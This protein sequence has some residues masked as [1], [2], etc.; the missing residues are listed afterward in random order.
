MPTPNSTEQAPNSRRFLAF[1]GSRLPSVKP[2]SQ[3]PKDGAA[4][5]GVRLMM[6]MERWGS[7]SQ[8]FP[9][10]QCAS[11]PKRCGDKG[12]W[13]R[14]AAQ[15][16]LTYR[17]SQNGDERYPLRRR[18]SNWGSVDD[19]LSRSL[20]S[21]RAALSCSNTSCDSGSAEA[22]ALVHKMRIRSS[23]LRSIHGPEVTSKLAHFI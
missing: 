9:Q 22:T 10:Q 21:W 1:I 6:V 4:V 19:F 8:Q 16:W 12:F 15:G 7:G 23:N 13:L 14:A 18:C 17:H 3:F 20:C 11:P 2:E 5:A